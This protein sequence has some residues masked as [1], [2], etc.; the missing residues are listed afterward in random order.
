[1]TSTGDLPKEDVVRD[2][3]LCERVHNREKFSVN[4]YGWSLS[5]K[6]E[7]KLRRSVNLDGAD[8]SFGPG[9]VTM[10]LGN[11][12]CSP[13]AFDSKHNLGLCNAVHTTE[14]A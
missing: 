13:P 10:W 2:V 11:V 12:N 3:M 8:N 4:I 5:M 7:Y 14:T 9:C 6:F 1:M